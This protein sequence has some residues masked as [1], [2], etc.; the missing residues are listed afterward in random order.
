MTNGVTHPGFLLAKIMDDKDLSQRELASRIDI[1]HSLLNNILKGNRNINVNIAISLEAAG[2]KTA[3]Y[4]LKKQMLFSLE[5]AKKDKQV[6]KKNE[7]IKT[8]KK[9]GKI[10]PISF[11]K[12]QDFLDINSSDD[13][14]K[15]YEIYN[16]NDFQSLKDKVETFNPTYFRKSSKFAENKENVIAWSLLAEFKARQKKVSPF[17][18][19]NEALLIEELKKCF[20]K[21]KNTLSTT[22]KILS[23][24]GIKFFILDRPSKTPVDGKSFMSND[25]PAIVL[26]LKY[27]RLDNFA[28]T[29]LHE[30]GHVFKHLSNPK[31]LGADFFVN[32]SYEEIEEF[33]ANNYARNHLIDPVLWNDFIVSNDEFSDDVILDFSEKTK[34]HPSIIRG[35]VC[36]EFPEYYRK[37]STIN[38]INVLT[39]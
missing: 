8:W 21:N 22:T 32:S 3:N 34:V 11:L 13:I 37:R 19:S 38:G 17:V 29:L 12:K 26:T 27:K 4:W 18:L 24:Y 7:S 6:I 9:L 35:R 31:Y 15:I 23:K 39:F 25:N 30:I 16:V 1:A 2:L 28:F 14:E 20:Y 10:V 33:E 5:V 36:F